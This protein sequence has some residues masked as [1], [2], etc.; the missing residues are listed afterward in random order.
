MLIKNSEQVLKYLIARLKNKCAGNEL[1]SYSETGLGGC[2]PLKLRFQEEKEEIQRRRRDGRGAGGR[3]ALEE[4]K[5]AEEVA[6][7]VLGGGGA[8]GW[9]LFS[10]DA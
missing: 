10:Q 8:E 6:E 9:C 2:K 7:S 5:E 3:G 4:E 1:H